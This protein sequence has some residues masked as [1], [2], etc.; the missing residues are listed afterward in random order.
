MAK[1][2]RKSTKR[3]TASRHTAAIV[4]QGSSK[5]KAS[6]RS[7]AAPKAPNPKSAK[8][9][10]AKPEPANSKSGMARLEREL[11]VARDR[12][13]ATSEILRVISRSPTDV[14]PVFDAIV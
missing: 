6:K 11:R 7:S 13:A 12:Q 5:A 10:F 14:Q 9:K 8:S 3:Q 4:K 2:V 1:R